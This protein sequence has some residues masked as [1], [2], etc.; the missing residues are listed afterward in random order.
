MTNLAIKALASTI[1]YEV[2]YSLLN[3]LSLKDLF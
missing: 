1:K 3:S 2:F